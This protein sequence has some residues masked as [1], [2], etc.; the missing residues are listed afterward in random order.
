MKRACA[1]CV[2]ARAKPCPQPASDE[3][4]ECYRQFQI[5]NY[6]CLTAAVCVMRPAA[7]FY[8]HLFKSDMWGVLFRPPRG[9]LPLR[10]QWTQQ[11]TVHTVADAPTASSASSAG[12]TRTR[13]FLRTLSE[14]PLQF[15]LMDVDEEPPEN[16]H[17][18]E[19]IDNE[20]NSQP[21]ADTV[22]ALIQHACTLPHSDWVQDLAAGLHDMQLPRTVEAPT[23]G[24]LAAPLLELAASTPRE[25]NGRKLL[26]SLH[27]DILETLLLWGDTEISP[28]EH[29]NSTIEYLINTCID[30]DKYTNM[31]NWLAGLLNRVLEVYGKV[32]T[33][34]WR[35]F[36]SLLTV[37]EKHKTVL[38]ILLIT[39]KHKLH[40][41]ELIP[42]LIGLDERY[43]LEP[44]LA[45]LFGQALACESETERPVSKYRQFMDRKRQRDEID[46]YVKLLYYAQMGYPKI[47]DEYH[48]KMI[49]QLTARVVGHTKSKCLRIISSYIALTEQTDLLSTLDISSLLRE[50]PSETMKLVVGGV[51]PFAGN[52]DHYVRAQAVAVMLNA[53]ED[54]FSPKQGEPSAKR[55]RPNS[56][57][58]LNTIESPD[59]YTSTVINCIALA[60]TDSDVSIASNAR[61]R[62]AMCLNS[63]DMKMRLAES[64]LLS[65]SV[66]ATLAKGRTPSV[67]VSAFL[68]LLFRGLRGNER[69]RE[70]KL[71]EEALELRDPTSSK[72][73]TNTRTY[74]GTFLS[75][76]GRRTRVK[77]DQSASGINVQ[78]SIDDILGSIISFAKDKPDV[79]QALCTD[80]A[81]MILASDRGFDARASLS[82][83]ACDVLSA[84]G[85]ITP[86]GVE[87]ARLLVDDIQG[88]IEFESVLDKLRE[89]T[90]CTEGEELVQLLYEEF[91]LRTD[92][93]MFELGGPGFDPGSDQKKCV[94]GF[95]VPKFSGQ[96]GVWKMT[97]ISMEYAEMDSDI[98]TP[99]F[100]DI[101][102]AFG[103]LANWDR[104]TI[105]QKNEV[106]GGGL[107]QLWVAEDTFKS[108][109][110]EG[111]VSNS[112]SWFNKMLSSYR[113][114]CKQDSLRWLR[115]TD[116]WP[117]RHFDISVVTE[118]IEGSEWSEQEMK[119]RCDIRPSD[120]LVEWAARLMVRR[121]YATE[122]DSGSSEIVYPSRS[123]E[124]KW[125]K[126]ANDRGLP[127]LAIN[128]A[129][130]NACSAEEKEQL[131][132][133]I[134]RARAMRIV[135]LNNNDVDMLGD[136]L[137][138]LE[139]KEN[140]L[141]ECSNNDVIM[142]DK[143]V[144]ALHQDLGS[145]SKDQLASIIE[146]ADRAAARPS[147]DQLDKQTLSSLY[148]MAITFYDDIWSDEL[149]EHNDLLN[150]MADLLGHMIE[151]ELTQR[152][153]MFVAVIFNRLDDFN[154]ELDEDTAR[155]ILEK[156]SLL[157][158]LD[159]TSLEQL[160]RHA[161]RFPSSLL[162]E[163][164]TISA[165]INGGSG[166]G[167]R[168]QFQLVC[169]VRHSLLRRCEGLRRDVSD[170]T[171]WK[172]SFD[173]LKENI[174]EN[175]YAAESTECSVL[176]KY[177]HDL[178]LIEDYDSTD[179]Q[180]K[181]STLNRILS[182][183]Y[184]K[185][186]PRATLRLSQLCPALAK[187]S[188]SGSEQDACMSRLLGLGKL[189]V[190]KFYEQVSVFL[191]AI[192]RPVVLSVLLT[193]GTIRRYIHKTG[194]RLRAD[195]AAQR[196]AASVACIVG[197]E[198]LGY[199]VTPLGEDSGLIEFVENSTRLRAMINSVYDL[200]QVDIGAR[201]EDDELILSSASLEHYRSFCSQVPAHAL[202][203][204]IEANCSSTEDFINKKRM[205]V[206][207]LSTLTLLCWIFGLGDRH[208][209]NILY[210]HHTG[211]VWCVDWA[212]LFAFGS[213]ELCPARL[214]R[215]L[216]AVGDTKVLEA[217]LQSLVSA[218]RSSSKL[219]LHVMKVSFK[220]MGEEFD[221]KNKVFRENIHIVDVT[222]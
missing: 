30:N 203:S 82:R 16:S 67:C 144:A 115:E 161:P 39:S 54:L 100:D 90:K 111:H 220:W 41:P 171:K 149:S 95:S 97:V 167:W 222:R 109:L 128:C 24:A 5:A 79:S 133:Q 33:V 12:T 116:R 122:Q 21:C 112:K 147:A 11:K 68:D 200:D 69:F 106:R 178:Y 92:P 35:C 75:T 59:T 66:P 191:D 216:Q 124:L 125:C 185:C 105:Q 142:W 195:Q 199:S 219:F 26:N 208:L 88:V 49:L 182:E 40:I 113:D 48:V 55:S 131:S 153:E 80:I 77:P 192:T 63:E 183:L 61:E 57:K 43:W 215:T 46:V 96:P 29:L 76:T 157:P 212:A 47:C 175:P 184:K 78:I 65:V 31:L 36:E 119:T 107:P 152:A 45:E 6:K 85:D 169:D 93:D 10:M 89:V 213:R 177:K 87:M 102:S 201:V 145:I 50:L 189:G 205:F 3:L 60:V 172:K 188:Y 53:F 70:A 132:W 110:A 135:G 32:V 42:T 56:S 170:P 148:E 120:C 13:V 202:R 126:I 123:H 91:R 207:T 86:V 72:L 214:T 7:K 58:L 151:L 136:A 20:L 141:S 179:T 218:L 162:A 38:R 139:L 52:S 127:H 17:E 181:T 8:Q 34:P 25:D 37:R 81:R 173:L 206:E 94:V 194:D 9:A 190:V 44:K 198:M 159:D 118:L 23:P 83:Q 121:A 104:L 146:S 15:D 74:Q 210:S 71:R 140:A 117:R 18:I 174:F 186:P 28:S 62:V 1:V 168:R 143:L 137:S 22:T 193:D 197:G 176:A 164:P 180:Q 14:N 209:E 154:G 108:W 187:Y 150:I 138:L 84:V 98:N 165:V 166:D 129:D 103:K 156:I 211:S 4:E 99:T 217:R 73:L 114:E 19:L 155:N 64:F 101:K 51:V 130:V 2:T 158:H 204:A 27:V 221:R 160:K 163:H 134:E 196:A